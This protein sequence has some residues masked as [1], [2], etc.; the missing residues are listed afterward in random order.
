MYND[1]VII[2][3]CVFAVYGAYALLREISMLF[4]RKNR[5]AAA[6]RVKSNEQL[7]NDAI[8]TAEQYIATHTFLE[9]APVLLCDGCV[10]NDLKKY[11]YEIYIK[12]TE[13]E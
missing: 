1:I 8:V 6:V 13:E 2:I 11:G 12:Q 5:V 4:S 9:R 3:L 10:P 7:Q